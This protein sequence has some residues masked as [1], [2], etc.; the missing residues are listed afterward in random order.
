VEAASITMEAVLTHTDTAEAPQESAQHACLT[1]LVSDTASR[2]VQLCT[3][4]ACSPQCEQNKSVSDYNIQWKFNEYIDLAN[5]SSACYW[6]MGD[7]PYHAMRIAAYY[8]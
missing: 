3:K 8:A 7:L 1:R 5:E 4:V 2:V 6:F